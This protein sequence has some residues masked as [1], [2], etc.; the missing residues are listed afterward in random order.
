MRQLL[1]FGFG[2][3]MGRQGK[4]SVRLKCF[5]WALLGLLSASLA[6]GPV[7][8][9]EWV[10]ENGSWKYRYD[11][12]SFE[13]RGWK[14]IDGDRDCVTECYYFRE[15]GTI[16]VSGETPDGYHVDRDGAWVKDGRR[17]EYKTEVRFAVT[18]DNL[19]HGQLI[20]FGQGSG[21]YEFLYQWELSQEL[22]AADLAVLNQET[23][24]VAD[25]AAYSGYPTFGTPLAVGEAALNAGFNLAACATNH[26][27]DKGLGAI[28]TTA[29]FYEARGIPYIGIQSSGHI[30]YEPYKLITVNG[31]RLALYDYT[32]G[33]NG[34][35]IPASHPHA[36]HL[37][38]NPN[39]VRA[40]LALGRAAADA[41]I[42][43]VHWGNE[44]EPD[45]SV[46]QRSWA[47][48]F[49]E[50]GVDVVV[51]GHPHVLQPVEL[52][53]REDGHKM[54]V[55]YSLGNM[56]SRQDR[57][58]SSIGGLAE[59]TITRTPEGCGVTEYELKP[60]ITHQTWDFSTACLLESYTPELAAAHRMGLS[61]PQWQELFARWTKGTGGHWGKASDSTNAK[62]VVAEIESTSTEQAAAASSAADTAGQA[63]SSTGVI[64]AERET[65]TAVPETT[66]AA[67][68]E[69]AAETTSAVQIEMTAETESAAAETEIPAQTETAAAETQ[70]SSGVIFA[71]VR[72]TEPETTAGYATAGADVVI[73]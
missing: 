19:I 46:Y 65:E 47:N 34:I 16:V 60:L 33:T 37:L 73:R 2:F 57:W 39:A 55:Y 3:G 13:N 1:R 61:I 36:V 71:P 21:N 20:R 7:Y 63:E 44:Y 56:V 49:L 11:D 72:E 53:E 6:A 31:V 15:D 64:Y 29:A 58:E 28:D 12:G 14:W 62:Q 51:G 48:V 43:F 30:E 32:Y 41:V 52:R 4:Q 45:P 40:E 54:V 23:I 8:A 9:D 10:Q 42:V 26:A 70:S 68:T 5:R 18:G 27:L 67:E 24:F 25:P 35:P 17:Q 50:S 59:F 38:T 66:V 22:K 69:T